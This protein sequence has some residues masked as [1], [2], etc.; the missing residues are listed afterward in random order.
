MG[1][2]FKL[3]WRNMWRN[4]RRTAIALVA[5]VLGLILLLFFDGMLIGSDQAIFGNAVRLYGGNIQAHQPGF[6]DKAS[7]LPILPLS[8]A[9]A[10]VTGATAQP[11]VV[12]AAKRINTGGMISSHE[13]SFPVVITAIEPAIEEP[14]SIQAENVAEGRY[15]LPDEGDA[16]FIGR[17]LADLLDAGVGDRVNLLGRSKQEEMRQR[18]M[19]IVGIYD[20]GMA[21]AEKGT[22]FMTLPEAQDLYNLRDEVTEVTINLDTIGKEASVI[23]ALQ[24]AL[25]GYEIDSWD[26]L[27][28]EIRETIT[29]KLAFTSVFGLIVIFIASIG[30][31]NIQLM[32]VF[33]RTREMGVLAALGMKGR[34]IMGLFMLEGTM[35]G[36]VGAVIGCVLGVALLALVGQK[37]IDYSFA[38]DIGGEMI[39]LMGDRIY[40]SITLSDVISR[41]ITVTIIVMIA[42]LYPAWQASRKEPAEALHHV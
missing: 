2:Y 39:A 7:R 9:D 33:E 17:G 16:I 41:G 15:L 18:T 36:V 4:W 28:P 14:L 23:A 1:T 42:S 27:R 11:E 5:I 19:T 21:A 13:G 32:A 20:L 26:T 24:A 38:S 6:R 8:D 40:P 12:A 25:P 3:A 37:G 31:L 29:T 10:V 30:I 35:I 34:Q 22:V